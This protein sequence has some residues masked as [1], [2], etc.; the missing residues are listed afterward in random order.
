MSLRGTLFITLLSDTCF[1]SPSTQDSTIDTDISIDGN[2]L[3]ILHGKTIHGLL[4]DTWLA[5]QPVLDPDC[6]GYALFGKTQSHDDA[7]L[8]RIGNA[9][10]AHAVADQLLYA[11]QRP[12]NPVPKPLIRSALT[13]ERT[14][15]AEDRETGTPLRE[16]MRRIRTLAAGIT[17]RADVTARQPLTAQQQQLLQHLLSLTRHAGLHRNRGCGHIKFAMKWDAGHEATGINWQSKSPSVSEEMIFLPFRLKLRAPCILSAPASD[18]NT[19][20]S[21]DYIPGATLR[22][23]I[24]AALVRH[25]ATDA[26]LIKILVSGDVRFLNATPNVGVRRSIPPSILWRRDKDAAKSDSAAN[27]GFDMQRLFGG[28]GHQTDY[29]RQPLSSRF[30]EQSGSQYVSATTR[31]GMRVHQQRHRETGHAS[32]GNS[33]VFVYEAIEPGQTF[34]GCVAVHNC[35]DHIIDLLTRAVSEPMWLGRSRRIGY[36][37]DPVVVEPSEWDARTETGR[38]PLLKIASGEKFEILLT[39]DAVVRNPNTG[40]FDPFALQRIIEKRFA[41]S[42]TVKATCVKTSTTSGYNRLWRSELPTITVVASGSTVWLQAERTI[43]A[44]EV[45]QLQ[46]RP[47]GERTAEGMGCFMIANYPETLSIDE[48]KEA[49]AV[50]TS[51]ISPELEAAQRHLYLRLAKT[52]A[53]DLARAHA[54]NSSRIPTTSCIGRVRTALTSDRW[55]EV[56]VVWFGSTDRKLKEAAANQLRNCR[57]ENTPLATVLQR[58]GEGALVFHLKSGD[59]K[60]QCTLFDEA[61]ANEIWTNAERDVQ[62]LYL[63]SLLTFMSRLKQKS[64][65]A[66]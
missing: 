45:R 43:T 19:T 60:Q 59:D 61:T 65:D 1:S 37:G 28:T 3:P 46:A 13:T 66:Q 42:A 17:L 16:S 64:E 53:V 35:D 15:T 12:A 38:K 49:D 54:E 22:G 58:A 24:A 63:Q 51:E 4:R 20:K 21:L 2:G 36:G 34:T 11:Q 5:L 18:P 14:M 44:E 39:S 8:L 32:A 30:Y 25:G 62:R 47:I 6:T 29:Q 56:F 40:E 9:E 27:P 23:A 50:L 41:T 48:P 26:D 33:T 52:Q 10:L 31:T 57:V 55:Q 7:C